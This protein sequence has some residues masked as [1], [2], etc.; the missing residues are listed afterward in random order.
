MDH[1]PEEELLN[2]AARGDISALAA[3]DAQGFLLK[4]GEAAEAFVGRIRAM[5]ARFRALDERM[6]ADGSCEVFPGIVIQESARIPDEIMDEAAQETDSRYGFAIRWAP[7]YFP[8]G[9]LGFLWGGCALS[10]RRRT[11]LRS[12]FSD[13]RQFPRIGTFLHLFARRTAL[14]R[15]LSRRAR[16]AFGPYFRGAFRLCRGAQRAPTL[17][18]QLL[19]VRFRRS[20]FPASDTASAWHSDCGLRIRL[21]SDSR[22]SVLDSRSRL[23]RL[24]ADP[25]CPAAEN[26]LPRGADSAR[27]RLCA[28]RG[29]P[30]PLHLRRDRALRPPCRV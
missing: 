26:L 7:G 30:L 25:Q 12:R 22:I 20:S 11:G 27:M 17:H 24:P 14:A 1:F 4:P 6:T 3:L 19:S 18:G 21:A 16:A 2:R 23:A 28:S 13:P 8:A 9:G 5:H 15:A 10:F 29:G